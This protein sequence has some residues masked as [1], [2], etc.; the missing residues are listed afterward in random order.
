LPNLQVPHRLLR[1]SRTEVPSLYRHYPASAVLRT[2]PPPRRARPVPRG[3]PVGHPWP[4]IGASRVA[5][6][7]LVCMP[8]PLPRCSGQVYSSL[9]TRPSV[10]AFP[11]PTA[12]SACASSFSRLAQRSLTLRP[13]HSHGHL[14]VA[15]IRRLQTLRHLHACSGCFR[16]ER[17]PGGACTRWKAPPFHG[18]RGKQTS[19]PILLWA[20]PCSTR[21][22][23]R[24]GQHCR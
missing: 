16:L 11:G 6:A 24:A 8:P 17:I 18:A 10:S 15:A 9:K 19:T 7:F 12:G 22:F 4:R 13:T 20:A 3:R 14:Y 2:S 21:L 5:Y 1:L 23:D